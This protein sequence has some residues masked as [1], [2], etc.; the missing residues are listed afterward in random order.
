MNGNTL[1]FHL[2]LEKKPAPPMRFWHWLVG[3]KKFPELKFKYRVAFQGANKLAAVVTDL[4]PKDSIRNLEAGLERMLDARIS[5][6]QANRLADQLHGTLFANREFDVPFDRARQGS[7]DQTRPQEIQVFADDE[8]SMPLLSNLPW[9]LTRDTLSRDQ[10][11]QRPVLGTLASHPMVRAIRAY[12][13]N[14]VQPAKLRVLACV[15]NYERDVTPFDADAFE[16]A[17]K[18]GLQSQHLDLEFVKAAAYRPTA[19]AT[20]AQIDKFRPHIFIFVGHGDSSSGTPLLRFEEW[21]KVEDLARSLGQTEQTLLAFFIACDQARTIDAPAAQSGAL[22]LVRHGLKSVIAMQGYV[23]PDYAQIFLKTFIESLFITH[24]IS[25][26]AAD[27]RQAME[28]AA[29]AKGWTSEWV[30]PTVFRAVG[31]EADNDELSR[32]L[33]HYQPALEQ[34]L[35]FVAEPVVR[36][37]RPELESELSTILR[38]A[39]G[40]VHIAG[41]FSNG[42]THLV[43]T[44]IRDRIK[45]VCENR[46]SLERPIFYF[47]LDECPDDDIPR[48][49]VERLQE[50]FSE[51]RSL[52]SAS[53]LSTL[54]STGWASINRIVALMSELDRFGIVIVIDHL[55]QDTEE[56]WVKL[57][58]QAIGLQKSLLVLVGAGDTV[59]EGVPE[60]LVP[61]FTLTETRDYFKKFISNQVTMAD[62]WHEETGGTPLLL[63]G[64]RIAT[65]KQ[66][67][68]VADVS[69]R[70]DAAIAAHYMELVNEDLDSEESAALGVFYW[71]GGL[72]EAKLAA[73]FIVST[74]P[75]ATLSSLEQKGVLS[76]TS[77]SESDWLSLPKLKARVLDEDVVNEGASQLI[78]SYGKILDSDTGLDELA[79]TPSGLTVL[80]AI[81]AALLD[82]GDYDQA[83][84]LALLLNRP[85]GENQPAE[86]YKFIGPILEE[87]NELDAP[88]EAWLLAAGLTRQLGKLD[89]AEFFLSKLEKAD[90]KEYSRADVLSIK[91]TI[92]KDRGCS[93]RTDDAVQY[94]NEA[95]GL[96]RDGSAGKIAGDVTSDE[97]RQ[98]LSTL[99]YNRA[100]V[101]EFNAKRHDDALSDIREAQVLAQNRD[102]VLG[103]AAMS[104]EVDFEVSKPELVKDWSDVLQTAATAYRILTA[105]PSHHLAYCCYQFARYYR[106]RPARSEAERKGNLA[107]AAKLYDESAKVATQVGD[108]KR[109]AVA[110]EHWVQVV[111]EELQSLSA[112]KAAH[113]L[114]VLLPTLGGY[115]GDAYAARI[116]RDS[117][118]LRARI[119]ARIAS[120]GA[121]EYLRKAA[122]AAT[123][124]VLSTRGEDRQRGVAIFVAYLQTLKA[125]EN[126]VAVDIFLATHRDL[127]KQWL[128]TESIKVDHPWEVLDQLINSQSQVK[129]K[130]YG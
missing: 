115:S 53:T 32:I 38:E 60:M 42:R 63:D 35:S 127:L 57:S 47:D 109:R 105:T 48:W 90:L 79:G 12:S 102:P 85:L 19:N 51:V 118:Y 91:A 89:E 40:I 44:V 75:L 1:Q 111:W 108:F 69:L 59:P 99:L 27:G 125:T 14:Q 103:A 49:F 81:Q 2:R 56:Y 78:E 58:Q 70:V 76:K 54:V 113:E 94:L 129:E 5:E 7:P 87:E 93:K 71:F 4:G 95:I 50:R 72:V 83:I 8:S 119:E 92:I 64:L 68:K 33:N 104:Q 11:G 45:E 46:S 28:R 116:L 73:R 18:D 26:S 13:Q 29:R 39:K 21:T 30:L 61:A 98:L 15:A 123:A 10:F 86:L 117:L 80:K 84:T 130:N 114:D 17:I 22:A 9:E 23:D 52:L 88:L 106:L 101:F 120:E 74:D 112:E 65:R 55:P 128:E 37:P 20:F 31:E 121:T 82:S 36:L 100:A 25:H 96:A 124:S 66:A 126:R 6:A 24:S 97:W 107:S 122:D 110:V 77:R 62:S 34:L 41:G 3:D 67:L 43:R 16:Q